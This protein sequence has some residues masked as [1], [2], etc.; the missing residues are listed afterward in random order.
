MELIR[1]SAV[2]STRR[3]TFLL[4]SGPTLAAVFVR[5]QTRVPTQAIQTGSWVLDFVVAIVLVSQA[6]SEIV[7]LARSTGVPLVFVTQ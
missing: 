5:F 4:T 6:K 2:T 7:H 3:Y 1:A